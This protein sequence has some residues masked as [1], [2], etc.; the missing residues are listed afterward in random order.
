MFYFI[1]QHGEIFGL[2]FH[3][4]FVVCPREEKQQQNNYC[5]ILYFIL[6]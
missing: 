4:L 3:I 6:I 5:S 1:S 2:V